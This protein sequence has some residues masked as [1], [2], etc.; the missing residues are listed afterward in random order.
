MSASEHDHYEL[1]RRIASLR[2]TADYRADQV[3][4]GV[5]EAIVDRMLQL[6]LNR[7]ELAALLGVTPARITNLLRGANNFTVRTLIDVAVAL[8][9]ALT[10]GL[11]PHEADSPVR[12]GLQAKAGRP[13]VAAESRV[14]YRASGAKSTYKSRDGEIRA[15]LAS[16]KLK[17]E[18]DHI[19]ML[20]E[21]D[22][23]YRP[24]RFRKAG[25]RTDKEK[26][27]VGRSAYYRDRILAVARELE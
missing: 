14:A 6:G 22:R 19:S 10:M 17:V 8:D 18:G 24:A 7:A 27:N 25:A 23:T 9:C 12:Y 3:I 15:H 16:G 13:V 5:T 21:R 4:D 11:I 20:H 26:T 1:K 2:D